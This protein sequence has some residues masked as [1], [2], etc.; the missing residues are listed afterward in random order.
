MTIENTRFFAPEWGIEIAR[1]LTAADGV[2]ADRY[3]VEQEDH[4]GTL[5][6][7]TQ[8]NTVAPRGRPGSRG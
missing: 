3:Q 5:F 7:V 1:E 4:R 8:M 2:G 6:F